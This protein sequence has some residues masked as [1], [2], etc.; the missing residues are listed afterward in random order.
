MQRK[1]MYSY[2]KKVWQSYN[3]NAGIENPFWLKTFS[4]IAE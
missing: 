4:D 2:K 3:I 1:C